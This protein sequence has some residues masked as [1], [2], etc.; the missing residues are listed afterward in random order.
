MASHWTETEEGLL[1]RLRSDAG[2]GPQAL[3]QKNLLSVAQ[4]R[5]LEGRDSGRFYSEEI[6]LHA[7]RKV[8]RSLGHDLELLPVAPG[9]DVPRE[10]SPRPDPRVDA[11]TEAQ[12]PDSLADGQDESARAPIA[13]VPVPAAAPAVALAPAPAPEPAP[14]PRP[15]GK[16]IY[17][18]GALALGVYALVSHT[19]KSA[20]PVAAA[21]QEAPSRASPAGD[22]AAPG[23][24]APGAA[25]GDGAAAPAAAAP[26]QRLGCAV[27]DASAL[28]SYTSPRG[29]KPASYVYVQAVR[30]TSLCV[31][32]SRAQETLLSLEADEARNVTGT[33]PF[34]VISE[35]L[36]AVRLF[37]QGLQVKLDAQPRPPGVVLN[38]H[39]TP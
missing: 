7:G 36:A 1:R 27:P 16:G 23:R 39:S 17:L 29:D 32:D 18:F 5:E 8:L 15:A 11:L 4:V 33:P 6:K 30:A 19:R 24:L 22:A 35:D 21:A 28:V 2:L 37:F 10:P 26:P 12:E 31:R 14:T 38:P 3:A 34:T 13:P 20:P 25:A 9:A